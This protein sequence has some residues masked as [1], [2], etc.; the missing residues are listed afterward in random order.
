MH[1]S[2]REALITA[3]GHIGVDPPNIRKKCYVFIS[4]LSTGTLCDYAQV[5]ISQ[6]S[7][8]CGATVN[9]VL[10]P[11]QS[12]SEESNVRDHAGRFANHATVFRHGLSL[13][14]ASTLTFIHSTPVSCSKK[15]LVSPEQAA[16]SQ[17]RESRCG[18]EAAFSRVAWPQPAANK[19]SLATFHT[20]QGFHGLIFPWR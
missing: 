17:H 7:R 1:A 18:R 16:L 9:V 8:R 15:P 4:L 12:E 6:L 2:R 20:R 3:D 5:R 11:P 14:A 13:G 10:S 19:E